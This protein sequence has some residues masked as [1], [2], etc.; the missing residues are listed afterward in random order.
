[1]Q[2]FDG[3]RLGLLAV[4]YRLIH[5]YQFSCADHGVYRA[6][7]ESEECKAYRCPVCKKRVRAVFLADGYTRHEIPF[8]EFVAKPL[9]K[10]R[11]VQL[12]AEGQEIYWPAPYH[13]S[14]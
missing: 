3:L 10:V 11:K 7:I 8:T 13:L 4:G 1:V 5:F 2:S 6:G 9:M 12:Q 14:L